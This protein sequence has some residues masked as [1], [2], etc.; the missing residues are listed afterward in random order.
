MAWKAPA[1][2]PGESSKDYFK[3]VGEQWDEHRKT[4][5]AAQAWH[6]RVTQSQRQGGMSRQELLAPLDTSPAPSLPSP[7]GQPDLPA[8]APTGPP[9]WLT[10]S[11]LRLTG[12]HAGKTW[13][14][15]W[16]GLTPAQRQT[17]MQSAPQP[18]N[19]PV[20]LDNP[21]PNFHGS[22]ELW[23][24]MSPQARQ[25]FANAHA[26]TG[27]MG[28]NFD[29]GFIPRIEDDDGSGT[30]EPVDGFEPGRV[31]GQQGIVWQDPI[32]GAIYTNPPRQGGRPISSADIPNNERVA[33]E[34]DWGMHF[35]RERERTV[36]SLGPARG[37]AD[38]SMAPSMGP[39][40]P[41][42]LGRGQFAH[43]YAPPV[44]V[45]ALRSQGPSQPFS[46]MDV[47]QAPAWVIRPAS[48]P[49]GAPGTP[50]LSMWG[51]GRHRPCFARWSGG[52]HRCGSRGSQTRRRLT[53]HPSRHHRPDAFHPDLMPTHYKPDPK[54][55][56]PSAEPCS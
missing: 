8:A 18:Q 16:A 31:P 54:L 53:Y 43:E 11:A 17:V 51:A 46:W 6:E 14:E 12:E 2:K 39:M 1:M 15:W 25:Q 34:Y 52:R 45:A 55:P 4:D 30:L 10:Q 35:Q 41:G 50:A 40:G 44:D 24:Q 38:R 28:Y 7:T 3:R 49:V 56:P 47:E 21:P 27:D 26:G 19:A 48:A 42:G 29:S 37:G 33:G 20:D 22:V 36:P 23:Q 13:E 32:T 5:P 9:S